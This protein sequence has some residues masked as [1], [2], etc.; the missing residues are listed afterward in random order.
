MDIPVLLI[1]PSLIQ[2]V[3]GLYFGLMFLGKL[4]LPSVH[5]PGAATLI[6]PLT[7]ASPGLS[8]LLHAIDRQTI[9]CRRLIISIESHD[10][11]AYRQSLDWLDRFSFPIEVAIAGNAVRCGQKCWNQIVALERIDRADEVIVLLDADIRPQKGWLSALISP[12]LDGTADIVT[13]YRWPVLDRSS[14]GGHV[15]A[16]IDRAIALLPRL[17]SLQAAWGGSLALSRSAVERLQLGRLLSTT[18]SDDLVIA[19]EA[20]SSGL[21]ILTRRALLVPSP[22]QAD[23]LNAWRFGRRQYQMVRV[24]LPVLWFFALS[25]TSMRLMGWSASLCE[26]NG[27]PGQISL[28]LLAGLALAERAVQYRVAQRLGYPDTQRDQRVQWLFAL[29]S[30]L[31]VFFHWTL[32]LAAASASRIRWGHVTYRLRSADDISIAKRSV[33]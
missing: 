5:R 17:G 1:L 21:V 4:R 8:A 6:L 24:Y 25:M 7:G 20:A 33:W 30:P 11:P 12:I 29:F 2:G 26:I 14:L 31:L 32:I 22:V 13:G 23:L 18:V 15:V 9:P 16:S 19:R 27:F 10:D 28:T 3:V